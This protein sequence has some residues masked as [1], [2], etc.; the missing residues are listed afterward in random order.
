MGRRKKRRRIQT[1]NEVNVTPLLD[2]VFIMLIFFVV[3]ASF[4]KEATIDLGR[5]DAP[6]NSTETS[7]SQNIFISIGA[8]DR[9]WIN[10]RAIALAALRPNLEKLHADDRTAKV[11]VV[12]EPRATTGV[13][14]RVIDIARRTG[15]Q[16]VMI[17]GG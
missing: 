1:K 12:T 3:T 5:F 14:V 17:A 13:L 11:I 8:D 4:L 7:T 6:L 9:I 15:I 2:V 10:R 16:E